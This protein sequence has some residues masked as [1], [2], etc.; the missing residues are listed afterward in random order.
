M[1]IS[2][3]RH[4]GDS[5][6]AAETLGI[7][8]SNGIVDF[9]VNL[10]PLGTPAAIAAEIA[11]FD[12]ADAAP[13][14]EPDA[15]SAARCLANTLDIPADE[16]VVGPGATALFSWVASAFA[17][18]VIHGVL[19]CYS[20]YA[21]T[22][23]LAGVPFSAI[24]TAVPDDGF[25]LDL[26]A[27]DFSSAEM[28]FLGSPNNPTGTPLKPENLAETA[29]SNPKTFF[30]F[31]ESFADFLPEEAAL[32]R[33]ET[34][35][36]NVAVVKSLTKFF[37][38]AGVRLGVLRSARAA[39]IAGKRPPWSVNSLALKIAPSL[40]RDTAFA[41][42]T[43]SVIQKL[44]KAFFNELK[45]IK[46]LHPFPSQA[47]FILCEL[48]GK[49]LG[50]E[51]AKRLLKR[52]FL[53]RRCADWPGLGDN[54]IRLA[55][56]TENDNAALLNA[57]S[58]ALNGEKHRANTQKKTRG[59]RAEI[60]VMVVG[61]SSGSGKSVVAAG[62][63]RLLARQGMKT[64]P[65]K[66]Q[67]MSLNSYVTPEGGE[68]GRAQAAQAEAA[69]IEPHT[70]MNPVLLKP[71][72]NNRSQIILDGQAAFSLDAKSY[73]AEKRAIREVAWNAFD[74]LAERFE[75]IVLEG[76]GSPAE[77]NLMDDD[78]VNMA[79][80]EYAEARTVLVADIDRGGV[81]ASILGTVKLLPPRHRELLAGIIINKFRGDA[82]LLD[83]GI[84][85]I[86]ALTGVPVLGILPF[87]PNLPLDEE[88]SLAL[89]SPTRHGGGKDATTRGLRVA[90]VKLPR[91]SNF[92]DFAPLER[93]DDATLKYVFNP[94]DVAAAD[95]IILPGTK[96]TVSDLEWLR[97]A[98]L[99]AEIASAA[100]RGVPIIGICGGFQML[101]A[102]IAD[103]LGVEGEPAVVQGLG[104]LDLR[105][106]LTEG[107]RL[108]R[109]E[110]ATTDA[111]PFAPEKT[112]FEGYEIHVGRS[113]NAIPGKRPMRITGK[114]G[115][116]T[117]EPE[118]AVSL[119]GNVVGTYVHGLFDS[120][121]I[122]G[123]VVAWAREKRGNR[124]GE[125]D[126]SPA[127]FEARD[128]TAALDM[129]ANLLEPMLRGLG[130][131]CGGR[132]ASAIAQGKDATSS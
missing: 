90:V 22:A 17:P 118:G 95:L 19:P 23:E 57:L 85:Q 107:K 110:G 37:S 89:D 9:S 102:E 1:D 2:V 87:I 69:G 70:D 117:D 29:L 130:T 6:A 59:H 81:F 47:N 21:E 15:R 65:F 78:F 96:N 126:T 127:G 52:G 104:L 119:G 49:T 113:S 80:A 43:R 13:Y 36:A 27:L 75:A 112:A 62:I 40:Y 109:V 14:P 86:E 103:P 100:E 72:G 125:G 5:A 8:T 66:A 35:P 128:K 24:A 33:R 124:G 34:L 46:G 32:F 28:V 84:E 111:C 88:D 115:T 79:M 114:D 25:A 121:E 16:L 56:R 45:E 105:T 106:E 60:R 31:D 98:G 10:N 101:G 120:A 92:T 71:E 129:I 41:E 30:V 20:G 4:G 18:S 91:I 123:A 76:A 38:I 11:A 12:A 53:I 67:N 93:R 61:T 63:C 26:D 131:C 42:K 116:P 77:I 39:E 64:A 97:S 55:V 58:E 99:A 7:E 122:A 82:S 3:D 51:L 74:R 44:K 68:I 54:F 50:T 48:R 132:N 108:S 73:Y 94:A 83:S